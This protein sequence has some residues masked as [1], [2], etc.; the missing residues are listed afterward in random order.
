MSIGQTVRRLR[1]AK[2]LSQEELADES[3][4]HRNY[5]GGIERGE[6]NVGIRAFIKLA[7]A[8]GVH[9]SKLFD[10]LDTKR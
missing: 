1:E 5:I 9:P 10:E 7:K 8:L 6:R 3:G 4:L 2:D